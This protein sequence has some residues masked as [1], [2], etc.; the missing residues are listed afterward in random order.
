M[1]VQAGMLIFTGVVLSIEDRI[2]CRMMTVDATAL[3][4]KRFGD[5]TERRGAPSPRPST[6]LLR[7]AIEVC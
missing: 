1:F 4:L 7:A 6:L 2:A 3:F 5:L